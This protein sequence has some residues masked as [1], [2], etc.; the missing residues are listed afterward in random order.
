MPRILLLGGAGKIALH[1]TPLLL[2]RG[3]SYHLTSVIRDPAQ[4][5]TIMAAAKGQLGT[6]NVLVRSLEDVTS[7]EKAKSIIEEAGAEWV[8]WSAGAGGKGGASRTYA[9]DRDACNHFIQASTSLSHVNTFLLISYIGS[10]RGRAPWWTDSDWASARATNEG[11]LK[12][13]H[14]AKLA[15]DECLT[16]AARKRG[17]GF[18]GIVLRPGTLTDDEKEGKVV[19]G[20][21][22]ASGGV[23]RRDVARV[24]VDLLENAK[25]GAWLD[26]LQGDEEVGD[27][28]TRVVKEGVDCIEGEDVEAIVQRWT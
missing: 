8:V 20:K 28:V 6:C 14:A 22:G 4:T 2:A 17:S 25:T 1:L 7:E 11:A 13:Y 5:E 18:R 15:A 3:S 26:L 19:L 12:D 23:A 16:A 10:R 24:T 21:T 27:A 9:I